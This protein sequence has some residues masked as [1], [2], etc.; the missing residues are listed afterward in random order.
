M[1][2]IIAAALFGA[3]YFYRDHHV[4][5]RPVYYRSGHDRPDTF[6][7]YFKNLAMDKMDLLFYAKDSNRNRKG[8]KPKI[9]YEPRRSSYFSGNPI[10]GTHNSNIYRI[11][12]DTYCSNDGKYSKAYLTV[13]DDRI[14]DDMSGNE[15]SYETFEK[16]VSKKIADYVTKDNMEYFSDSLYVRNEI[17]STDYEIVR[18]NKV[19]DELDD[20]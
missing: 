9:K 19:Y 12:S 6:R 7:Q 10:V 8:Y 5:T 16:C 14:I 1:N 2:L 3:G 15:I 20:E 4:Y 17:L 11:D 13:Y 18:I